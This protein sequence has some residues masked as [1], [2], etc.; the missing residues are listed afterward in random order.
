MQQYE[1]ESSSPPKSTSAMRRAPEGC[2]Y[3]IRACNRSSSARKR[4]HASNSNAHLMESGSPAAYETSHSERVNLV[5]S[6]PIAA[7]E[8]SN[9]DQVQQRQAGRVGD[10]SGLRNQPIT[11]ERQPSDR[12]RRGNAHFKSSSTTTI[13]STKCEPKEQQQQPSALHNQ[14]SLQANI[15][16]HALPSSVP[17]PPL[18][19]EITHLFAC[20][21]GFA[22]L[23][24]SVEN[25]TSPNQQ[26]SQG[27]QI[28][29]AHIIQQT[30]AQRHQSSNPIP[31]RN[32]NK[33]SKLRKPISN[34]KLNPNNK[35][36]LS[37]KF[38]RY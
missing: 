26:S 38:F 5:K 2:K 13:R 24:A 4:R 35:H 29:V 7:Y 16:K 19:F 36:R 25:V 22:D 14:Q 28:Q 18:A 27:A 8:T 34:G 9:S 12:F 30:L 1:A 20:Q 15:I 6:E 37:V 17:H 11:P 32:N 33:R 31:P 10:P 23:E 3:I 21:Y